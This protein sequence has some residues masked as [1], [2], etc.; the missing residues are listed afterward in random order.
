MNLEQL[1]QLWTAQDARLD[2]MVRV[3]TEMLRQQTI[4]GARSGL[5][6]WRFGIALELLSDIVMVLLLG[7]FLVDHGAEL[8]FAAPAAVLHV[9]AIAHLAS[10]VRLLVG[11]SFAEDG[12]VLAVQRRLE[13]LRMLRIRTTKWVFVL[14]PLL[15]TPLL[16]VALRGLAGVD[17]YEALD[18][19]WLLANLLFG[20]LWIPL[21]LWLCHRFADR[22]GR[23]PFV[24]Q[25]LR[26]IAGRSLAVA[27]GRLAAIAEF[28]RE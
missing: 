16:I 4:A 7:S 19:G 12:P 14:A 17:A 26:D 3:N 27:I 6:G 25:L 5:R 13:A 22:A 15:W 20:V 8:R 1:Q 9:M 18:G 10:T 21:L 28:E 23:L 11:S 2:R 24:Q